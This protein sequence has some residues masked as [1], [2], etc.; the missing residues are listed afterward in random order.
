MRPSWVRKQGKTSEPERIGC[1]GR[2]FSD[3][4]CHRQDWSVMGLPS[5]AGWR[6]HHLRRAINRIR[7]S[8]ASLL[9]LV[10][11][12][13][14]EESS[15]SAAY[16]YGYGK[17]KYGYGYGYGYGGYDT[18]SAYA[19]YNSDAETTQTET[20]SPTELTSPN[21]DSAPTSLAAD[22]ASA[23]LTWRKQL[24]TYRRQMARWID[25]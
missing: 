20:N 21:P 23:A 18:R 1:H 5:R 12:A 9:G 22:K 4:A 14:K 16:G 2:D 8:G 17:S 13:V 19:Y 3:G 15:G 6:Q 24:N 25:S 7:S 10:T 11:N